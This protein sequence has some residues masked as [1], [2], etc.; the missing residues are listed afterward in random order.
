[1]SQTPK[2]LSAVPDLPPFYTPSS[3]LEMVELRY[4]AIPGQPSIIYWDSSNDTV[5]SICPVPQIGMI[6]IMPNTLNFVITAHRVGTDF[7]KEDAVKYMELASN[8]IDLAD[9]AGAD[10]DSIEYRLALDAD[11]VTS[12]AGVGYRAIMCVPVS[13][14]V[15]MHNLNLAMLQGQAAAKIAAAMKLDSTAETKH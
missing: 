1:M 2:Q 6:K 15:F 3:Q 4:A 7:S 9:L 5:V 14:E 10:I 8:K 12:E 13:T 11:A